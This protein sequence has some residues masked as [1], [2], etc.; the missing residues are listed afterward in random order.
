MAVAAISGPSP[1]WYLT[2]GTG[3]VTLV[4]LTVSVVLG[5]AN[6][7]RLQ[8]ER[9][10]RF[11]LDA[12]HRSASLLAVVFLAIHVMTSVLDA[13]APIQLVDA[14]V[15]FVSA[16]R[17]VWLGLGAI[18]SDLLIA[19]AVTSIVRRRL[20]YTAWR[21]THWLAYACWPIALIHAFGTGSDAKTTWMLALAAGATVAVLVSVW[22]R[23]GSGWPDRIG[24]RGVALVASVA[25]PIALVAWLSGGPLA[26]G[27]AKRAGTPRSLLP[28]S[29]AQ[30]ASVNLPASPSATT[31]RAVA[32]P[33]T[34]S[35]R[36]SPVP[37]G[38]THVDLRLTATGRSLSAL[39][40]RIQGQPLSGGG[41]QMSSSVV[42]LGTPSD[43]TL[44]RG[45]VTSLNG[46]TIDAHVQSLHEALALRAQLSID[47]QTNAITGNVTARPASLTA[48]HP[49]GDGDHE[50]EGQ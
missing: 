46:S 40:I 36:Q 20:G 12:V 39:D 25:T 22:T 19:V 35:M 44:Y 32:E 6:V 29:A 38:L 21:V 48:G 3:A 14:F 45:V 47:P 4:L 2:R 37:E 30:Y 15:P 28:A 17:P 26:T 13:F 23:I 11:V 24:T 8:T 5:I 49:P 50:G 16:Y 1:L 33:V 34:G 10:P 7:Q 43:P 9:V 31:R 18:A 41:V 42:T 27:W